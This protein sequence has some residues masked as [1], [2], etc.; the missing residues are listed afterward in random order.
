MSEKKITLQLVVD[1]RSAQQ[2]RRVIRELLG[3]AQKLAQTLGGIGLGGRGGGG[4]VAGTVGGPQSH[5]SMISAINA[6]RVGGGGVA[7]GSPLTA[8]FQENASA[9]KGLAAVSRDS[10]RMMAD[11]IDRAVS[12]QK[13]SIGDLDAQIAKL[14][15]RYD[16]LKSRQQAAVAAG[17]DPARAERI[18]GRKGEG[19][20]SDQTSMLEQRRA[21]SESIKELEKIRQSMDPATPPNQPPGGGGGGGGI[22]GGFW[23]GFKQM[24]PTQV[25]GRYA[26]PGVVGGALLGGAVAAANEV[27]A[28]NFDVISN[29][30]RSQQAIGAM[31]VATK[32]G[33]LQ[34][35]MALAKVFQSKDT[36]EEFMAVGDSKISAAVANGFGSAISG[37]ASGNPNVIGSGARAI[38]GLDAAQ[39]EK[40][41]S[42]VEQYVQS[43][44]DLFAKLGNFQA[45]AGGQVQLMRRMGVGQSAL[46][47]MER[48]AARAGGMDLGDVGGAFESLRGAGRG[49][50]GKNFPSIMAAMRGGMDPGAAADLMSA[51]APGGGA[52]QLLGQIG[53]GMDVAAAERIARA[54]AGAIRGGAYGPT[55][56]AALLGPA[57]AFGF[58]GDSAR[59][60]YEAG[61]RGA[62]LAGVGRMLG[63]G[64]DPFGAG[65]SILSANRAVGQGGDIYT[66]NA[67]A[68]LGNNPGDLIA[69]AGGEITPLMSAQGITQDLAKSMLQDLVGQNMRSRFI[70]GAGGRNPS[71]ATAAMTRLTEQYGGDPRAMFAAEG[72]GARAQERLLDEL[73][74]GL[75]DVMPSDFPTA[76]AGRAGMAVLAGIGAPGR[77]GRGLGDASAGSLAVDYVRGARE[78]AAQDQADFLDSPEGKAVTAFSATLKTVGDKM[79][80]LGDLSDGADHAAG[81]L[82]ALAQAADA[83]RGKLTGADDQKAAGGKLVKEQ[84]R[85]I[86]Q[87]DASKAAANAKAESLAHS[88][89]RLRR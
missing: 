12:Q 55:S 2:A 6:P 10:M 58:T 8:V 3:D 42:Y 44:P 15:R 79:L 85:A 63:T 25:G 38:E 75:H 86:N 36:R 69:A 51:A 65:L 46:S 19:M 84:T 23:G 50:A 88:P 83:L 56:G 82:M 80:S 35:M 57:T 28:A 60:T 81:S 64:G 4:M 45:R 17:F 30:A 54:V 32:A 18:Y 34:Y 13:R 66:A 59:D 48:A 77:R 1:E 68:Q 71:R 24:F 61:Q 70:S 22:F 52:G 67:L 53:G 89:L 14:A 21:A 9:L 76:S 31:G 11:N 39:K 40:L 33:D 41:R 5:M 43:D 73:G 26:R 37:L 29:R 62:G 78:T 27:Q 16:D 47:G 7:R 20:A 49:F 87:M 72:K 74:A